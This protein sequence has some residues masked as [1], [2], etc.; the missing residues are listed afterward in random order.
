MAE[1]SLS[2]HFEDLV[3][4]AR[5]LIRRPGFALVVILTFALGIGS[6]TAIVGAVRPILFAP[7]PYPDPARL[8]AI[9]DVDVQGEPFDVAHGTYVELL[10][11]NR[12]FESLAVRSRWQP[13]LASTQEP[14]RL[15]GARV[16]IDYFA[17]LGV[18]PAVGRTF[19][20]E[21]TSAGGPKVV[22]I[23][24]RLAQAAEAV[25]GSSIELDGEPH[26]VVGVMPASFGDV[27]AP[28]AEVWTPLQYRTRTPFEAREWGHHLA[29]VG[30]LSAGI[31]VDQARRE[32]AAI[33]SL[34]EADSPRAPWASLQNGLLVEPL[35]HTLTTTARPVLWSVLGAVLLLLAIASVNVANLLLARNADCRREIATRAALGA[36]PARVL[37]Q[38]LMESI[39]LA[40]LG[41]T[42]GLGV[43]A[44][45]IRA[46]VALAP[47]GLPRV[48]EIALD[49]SVFVIALAITAI[50][51]LAVGTPPALEAMR[52]DLRLGLRSGNRAVGRGRQT[53]R[54]TLVVTQVALALVLLVGAGLLLR[55]MERI[56]ATAPGFE[57]DRIVTMQVVATGRRF[58]S[59]DDALRLFE[60]ALEAVRNVPGVSDAALVN[61][62]P[63]SGDLDVY[64]A[65]FEAAPL[66]DERNTAGA[67]RYAV[68]PGWFRTMRLPLVQGRLLDASDRPP[69]PVAVL[70]NE[71]FAKRRFGD[72]SPI[73]ERVRFG[74]QID[75]EDQWSTIVGV[76]G[77]VRHSS[78]ALPP[79]DAFY[80]AMGHWP[81]VDAVQTLVVRTGRDPSNL[82]TQVERAIWS[83]DPSLPITR[84]A[85]MADVLSASE[86]RR[87]FALTV[88]SLFSAAAL[89]LA[90]IGLYGVL[91]G[92]VSERT[93]EIG[94][95]S[96]LGAT[97]G[98]I[99]I[100][101][102]RQGLVLT[103]IG[104]GLGLVVAAATGGVLRSLLFGVDGFDAPTYIAVSVLLMGTAV[105]ASLFPAWRA[106]R[107]EPTVA[108]RRD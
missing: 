97:R 23:A 91:A 24:E 1:T 8:V 86:A 88:F 25:L 81:W 66:S 18:P 46:F 29:M 67:L 107:L 61:Q 11:R 73:G 69:A 71:S 49:G 59:N 39:V 45:G 101:I 10:E 5:A 21:E 96:A 15:E 94:L 37:R 74:P 38:R 36:G 62:L 60:Q 58:E 82:V 75:A 28:R 64:G 103:G 30:R 42:V 56:L 19:T 40:A 55:S 12:S 16:S 87:T 52:T 53:L 57:A 99:L 80:V 70:I 93:S 41:G 77:D 22:I 79:P 104:V 4:A 92:S 13:S 83:V 90:A 26:T 68:T 84:I 65:V 105:S 51:G 3:Q 95:R 7:L 35:H 43:A 48:G 34:P 14:E 33:A 32:L 44:A 85:T 9:F 89:A 2:T 27:L 76:V 6:S 50:V 78:L 20:I 17:V 98:R 31:S 106:A 108:L 100:F 47:P 102:L 72:R 54:K 63:L